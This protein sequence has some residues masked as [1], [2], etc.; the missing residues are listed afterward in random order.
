M[1]RGSTHPYVH[2]WLWHHRLRRSSPVGI[3][4]TNPFLNVFHSL[5]LLVR[6][7]IVSVSPAVDARGEGRRV[8]LLEFCRFSGQA[9]SNLVALTTYLTRKILLT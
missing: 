4:R 1:E 3:T 5:L 6:L 8:E 2:V 7:F 9:T